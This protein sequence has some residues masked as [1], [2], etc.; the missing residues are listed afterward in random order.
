MAEIKNVRIQTVTASDDGT[1][2]VIQ[3]DGTTYLKVEKS[4]GDLYIGGDIKTRESL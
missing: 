4:T 3:F 1:Y 2:I